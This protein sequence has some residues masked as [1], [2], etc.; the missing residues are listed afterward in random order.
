[1]SERPATGAEQSRAGV[2]DARGIMQGSGSDRTGIIR[3]QDAG[4][5]PLPDA[6]SKA[7]HVKYARILDVLVAMM[8][9][10]M[11]HL[12][13]SYDGPASRRSALARSSAG[14][15]PEAGQEA[16]A[17]PSIL[18]DVDAVDKC[19][20]AC[21]LTLPALRPAALPA[22]YMRLRRLGAPVEPG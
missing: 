3:G 1:M 13:A 9:A 14:C 20:S 8:P 2:R 12:H 7:P 16:E 18:S 5:P 4:K 6:F 10:C 17:V 19:V 11:E 22:G 21:R 15:A